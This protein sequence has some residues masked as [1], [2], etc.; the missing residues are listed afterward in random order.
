M[1]LDCPNMGLISAQNGPLADKDPGADPEAQKSEQYPKKLT[2]DPLGR[3]TFEN[4]EE[5]GCTYI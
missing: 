2:L 1:H 3:N 4:L 5:N